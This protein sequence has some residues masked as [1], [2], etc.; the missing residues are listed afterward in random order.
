MRRLEELEGETF[1]TLTLPDG[2]SVRYLRGSLQEG[3]DL[4]E[5]F[6]ACMDGR[7]HWLLPHVRK[8]DAR[9]GFPALIRVRE[10]GSDDGA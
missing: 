7:E 2:T 9:E 6:L 1:G 3:G 8:M 5:A 4:C 10:G